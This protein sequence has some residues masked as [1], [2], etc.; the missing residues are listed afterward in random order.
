MARDYQ[1]VEEVDKWINDYLQM[2][3]VFSRNKK[4]ENK[5]ESLSNQDPSDDDDL[6]FT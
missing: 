2:D 5:E 4:E 6:V 1:R 3:S